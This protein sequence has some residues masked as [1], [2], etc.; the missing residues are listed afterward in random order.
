MGILL[1]GGGVGRWVVGFVKVS[2]GWVCLNTYTSWVGQRSSIG[3]IVVGVFFGPR[4]IT[5][6]FVQYAVL[7][8]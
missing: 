6:H 3:I 1:R 2:Y 4:N 5:H 8:C 7:S